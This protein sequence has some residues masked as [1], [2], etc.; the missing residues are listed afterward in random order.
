MCKEGGYRIH[1]HNYLQEIM[2]A[3]HFNINPFTSV[4]FK[5]CNT[6]Q[7]RCLFVSI[8]GCIILLVLL[9]ILF[10]KESKQKER[11]KERKNKIKLA[12]SSTYV[13]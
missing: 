4:C 11:K 3:W 12:M 9:S 5:H 2:K 6:L 10:K 13:P 8:S 1:W 7:T